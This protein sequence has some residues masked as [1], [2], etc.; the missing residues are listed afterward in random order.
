MLGMSKH[1]MFCRPLQVWSGALL[2]TTGITATAWAGATTDGTTHPTPGTIDTFSGNFVIPD[3]VGTTVGDALF[4]SFSTFSIDA[5]ESATFTGADA[6]NNVISRVTGGDPSIF[7]GALIS[8]IGSANFYFMN[9]NGV[10]FK[11]GAAFI[12][13]GAFYAT[14]SDYLNLGQDGVVFANPATE[15]V[16]TSSPPSSFGFLDSDP[17]Q[18]ALEGTLLFKDFNLLQPDGRT[19]SLIA[20]DITLDRS[21]TDTL[22]PFGAPYTFIS[23]TGNGIEMVS[24]GS[25]GEV[26]IEVDGYGLSSF[27]TLGNVTLTGNSVVD[28]TN[29][30]IRGGDIVIDDALIAPG[31]FYALGNAP[32][33]QPGSIDIAA[34]DRV[35]ITGTEPFPYLRP[36]GGAYVAGV[37]VF[38]GNPLDGEPVVAGSDIDISGSDI[39]VSGAAAVADI[40]Y[41]P[42]EAGDIE[43]TGDAVAIRNGGLVTNINAFDGAGGDITVNADEVIL[44]GEDHSGSQTGLNGTSNFSVVYLATDG[45]VADPTRV[46]YT[47]ADAGTITVNATGPG[48]LTIRNGASINTE[49]RAFGRGG[50]IHIEASNMDLSRDGKSV[51]AIASQSL[52]AGDA[53]NIAVHATDHINIQGGFEITG[54]SVGTGTGGMVSVTVDGNIN[55]SGDGSGIASATPSPTQEVKDLLGAIYSPVFGSTN[56]SELVNTLN[57]F[58]ATEFTANSSLYEVMAT[59]FSIGVVTH[60]DFD[61]SANPSAGDA[62]PVTVIA[63]TLN[64]D[65][66]SRITSST[67]SDGNGGSIDIQ[68]NTLAM[69]NG[70][71]IRSRSGLP[72]VQSGE[73]KVGSGNGG[74][75]AIVA[76][77]SVAMH[78]G[79]SV[80]ASTVG[81]GLAGNIVVDAGNTLDLSASSITSEAAGAGDGGDI[82]VHASTAAFMTNGSRVSASTLGAGRA[83]HIAVDAGNTL[84]LSASS[85]TSEAEGAGDGGNIS[86]TASKS[87]GIRGGSSVSSSSLG[88]GLA[89]DIAIDAGG[90]LEMANSTIATEAKISDGGN[91]QLAATDRVYLDNGEITTSVESGVGGGGNINIDPDFVVMKH[92][93]ILANAYGGPGGNIDI[94]ASHF[95]ATPDSLVDASSALGIDGTVNISSPDQDVSEDLAVLPDNYLDV[96]GLIRDRCSAT[97]GAS[98][99]VDAG[100][101]GLAVDP[102]GYLP[103]FV[104]G[105]K[106]AG[107]GQGAASA[108]SRGDR[109]WAPYVHQSVLSVAEMSCD[110]YPSSYHDQR[111]SPSNGRAAGAGVGQ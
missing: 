111:R 78:T 5:G 86:L 28:A 67:S 31:L 66:P 109:W 4:H 7:N 37:T 96:T 61:P 77:E 59:L 2:L 45:S 51:G 42:G 68:V 97:A 9:P 69:S 65:G 23:A 49:S 21:P 100:P 104:A 74:D 8:Q 80:S 56:F 18:I 58:L 71:E 40:R 38:G 10:I 44:D 63:T 11:E 29:I 75:I 20:G 15:S 22:N 82:S 19:F 50:D 35:A 6:I 72:D 91:V 99:L 43:I 34:R 1:R 57:F 105:T 84:D 39:L 3:T 32:P 33:T 106:P 107:G 94:V 27:D 46:Q 55:I 102:D 60:P 54:N 92:G 62:G 103:S 90:G 25:P 108:A 73:L 98:S 16:L 70:A 24:V 13:D 47:T 89:G 95:I 87:V 110:P 14:T 93:R 26:A 76:S 53:G 30:Y 64:M 48:G 79:S 52:F 88:D 81:D 12:V 85:I 101:G 41:G 36:D 17:G 83:G